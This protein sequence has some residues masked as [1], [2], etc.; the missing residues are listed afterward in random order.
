MLCT[1]T[2][3]TAP[4]GQ[5]GGHLAAR[6]PRVQTR[7]AE[8]CRGQRWGGVEGDVVAGHEI[9]VVATL[10]EQRLLE[11]HDAIDAA[12]MAHEVVDEQDFHRLTFKAVEA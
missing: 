11:G 9:D 2:T 12:A 5:A 10:G 8:G 4:R 1:W 6:S 7:C 3:S